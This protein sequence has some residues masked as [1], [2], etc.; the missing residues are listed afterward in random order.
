MLAFRVESWQCLS[1]PWAAPIPGPSPS[2]P[3]LHKLASSTVSHLDV[4]ELTQVCVHGQKCLVHQLLMVIHPEQ[5]V[6]LKRQE[7]MNANAPLGLLAT[8]AHSFC[9]PGTWGSALTPSL[10]GLVASETSISSSVKC[11]GSWGQQG[12]VGGPSL[13]PPLTSVILFA[14]SLPGQSGSYTSCR[15]SF[16]FLEASCMA[17]GQKGHAAAKPWEPRIGVP[18]RPRRNVGLQNSSHPFLTYPDTLTS[19]LGIC[20]TWGRPLPASCEVWPTQARSALYL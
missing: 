11:A 10:Q 7:H 13:L 3:S 17:V 20:S 19:S 6:V 8:P 14:S 2:P 15:H 18:Q 12:L 5:I 1:Q 4:R 16:S 9:L